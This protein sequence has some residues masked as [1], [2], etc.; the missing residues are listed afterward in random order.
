MVKPA[1]RE[2]EQFYG[3]LQA[4]GRLFTFRDPNNACLFDLRVNECYV[5][6]FLVENGAIS[7]SKLADTLGVH[8]SNASRIATSLQEQGLIEQ[9]ADADDKRA[10]IL[11]PTA[12]GRV[13]HAEIKKH[14]VSRLQSILS[15]FSRDDVQIAMKV[16]AELAADAEQRIVSPSNC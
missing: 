6:D 4:Y 10:V 7:V 8:K 5:L 15:E 13:R 3:H 11:Q 12:Q 9:I 14:F 1:R 2:L 16:V